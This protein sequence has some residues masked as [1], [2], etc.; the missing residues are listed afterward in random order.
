MGYQKF[1]TRPNPD[2]VVQVITEH[3]EEQ[4]TMDN[5]GNETT[6]LEKKQL[7]DQ[8]HEKIEEAHSFS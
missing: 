2:F 3:C 7:G 4:Q 6:V 5:H 1:A 8:L